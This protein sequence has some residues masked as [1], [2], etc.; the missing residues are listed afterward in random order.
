M[1]I[2][3]KDFKNGFAA[4][5]Q[6][7]VKVMSYHLHVLFLETFKSYGLCPTGLNIRKKPFIEFEIHNL[8]II[9]KETLLSAENDLLEALCVGICDQMFILEK[10][11]WDEL[12]KL[13]KNNTEE[14]IKNWL[15]KLHVHL[16]KRL[17][18]IS[19]KKIKKL[20]KL[21]GNS[22]IKDNLST[23]FQE[24]LD[25]FTFFNDFSG[26]CDNFS[27]DVV[28]ATNLVTLEPYSHV[29]CISDLSGVS[30]EDYLVHFS[31]HDFNKTNSAA[32]VN[33]RLQGKFVNPN[34][35]NLSRRNLTNNEIS[36]FSKGLKFVPTPRGINKALIKE[37]LE[38][39]G[40][41]LRLMWHFR[42]DERE[43]S[44]DPFK[45]KSKFDPK[46]KD[47]AIVLYLSRL[48]E[49]ISSL[50][51]KVGY[52]NFTKGERDAVYS[53]KYVN[54]IIIKKAD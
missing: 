20:H 1:E 42:N 40:R 22:V 5:F 34:V 7:A 17:K 35:V 45:K 49:E 41:K 51:Y 50:D 10:Q 43:L 29:S 25:I 24:D 23:R 15:I 27:P 13:H 32:L 46:R 26:H 36:L 4:A 48:E 54:S 21:S 3:D 37:E 14:D 39:Y 16:E 53:L 33:E 38:A 8:L 19:K 6:Y 12:Q 9:W 30:Q 28:N 18:K 44:Y 31:N 11:F 47:A 52:S 2:V